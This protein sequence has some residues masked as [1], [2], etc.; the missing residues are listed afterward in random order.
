MIGDMWIHV[1]HMH[2]HVDTYAWTCGD[3]HG[4]VDTCINIH[5]YQHR[6][7]YGGLTTFKEFEHKMT[8]FNFYKMTIIWD[9]NTLLPSDTHNQFG[10]Y[11][12]E[13]P[14]DKTMEAI[15]SLQATFDQ[16][17]GNDKMAER[18]IAARDA[19]MFAAPYEG[20]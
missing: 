1:G 14:D 9:A 18:I 15:I 7:M 5:G 16:D 6:N 11:F 10:S 20:E 13:V 3:M 19:Y 17:D 12:N 8:R 2:G 4:H